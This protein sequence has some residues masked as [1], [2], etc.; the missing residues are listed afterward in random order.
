MFCCRFVCEAEIQVT[1]VELSRLTAEIAHITPLTP[2]GNST[3]SWPIGMLSSSENV[4]FICGFDVLTLLVGYQE[5]HPT[6]KSSATVIPKSL[7]LGAGISCS[8]LTWCNFGK[9]AS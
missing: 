1:R 2:D 4:S 5:G 3:Q 6:C 7:L 8:N 9:W